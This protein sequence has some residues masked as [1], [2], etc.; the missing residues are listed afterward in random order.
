ME[1]DGI[2][3]S[4]VPEPSPA[5]FTLVID[6]EAV[7]LDEVDERLH[8]LNAPAALVWVCL[9]GHAAVGDLVTELSEELGVPRGTV[10]TDTLGVLRELGAQGLLRGVRA[11]EDTAP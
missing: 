11:V 3:E 8:H 6:G 9:D 2:D 5:V 10:L 7:L 1:P 4:F